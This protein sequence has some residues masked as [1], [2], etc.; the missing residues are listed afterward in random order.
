M[1]FKTRLLVLLI[2]AVAMLALAL[3]GCGGDDET[4]TTAAAGDTETTAGADDTGVDT[5]TTAGSA[6]GDIPIGFLTPF[7]GE[8]GA[9][10]EP[11]QNAAQ[12]A[13]DDINEAGGVL[14]RNLSLSAQDD[15]SA[16]EQGIKGARTLIGVN[17][18]VAIA[19][20]ISDTAVGVYP[21]CEDNKVML[22]SMAAGTTRMDTGYGEWFFRTVPSDSFDGRVAAQVLLDKGFDTIGLIYENDESRQSIAN[23]MKTAFE[24]AG[25]TIATEL[26]FTPGQASY[27]SEL[28]KVSGASPT[29]VWMGAG[30]ESGATLMKNASQAGYDWQWMVSSDLAVPE[31]FELVGVDAMEGVLSETPSADTSIAYVQDWNARYEERFNAD[32]TGAFQP[33]SYDQIIIIA[34]AMQKAGAATGEAISQNYHAVTDENP[35]AVVVNSYADGLAALEAGDDIKYEGVSGPCVFDENGNTVGSYT[36]LVGKAGAWEPE[37]FYPASFFLEE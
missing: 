20:V 10:G 21:I 17:N 9:Y 2:A 27:S 5:E 36:S 13:I 19:G 4:T 24:A 25:G 31:M 30:Q 8:L 35:N 15:A 29:A 11:W 37:E 12:M 26:A 22:T 32:P 1:G 6:E 23:A 14:G 33:N 28:I 7:T 34:L 16:V 3:V 18:V